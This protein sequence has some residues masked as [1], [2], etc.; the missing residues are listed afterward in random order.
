MTIELTPE[1]TIDV[2]GNVIS[3]ATGTIGN[4]LG[5]EGF[6]VADD[7]LPPFVAEIVALAESAERARTAGS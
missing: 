1:G 3:Q 2:H 7:E 5:T 4:R 6:V